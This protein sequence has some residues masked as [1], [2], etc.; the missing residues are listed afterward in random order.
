M[1]AEPTALA[2][3]PPAPPVIDLVHCLS[4]TFHGLPL[5]FHFFS[6]TFHC[7]PLTFTTVS[8]RA[9]DTPMILGSAHLW[10]MY[11]PTKHHSSPGA[12]HM[13]AGALHEGRVGLEEPG[14]AAGRRLRRESGVGLAV[15]ETVIL[16]HPPL[17]LV[18]V[19]I[20]MKRGRQ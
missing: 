1:F 6:L 8:P 3:R 15:G 5:T 13:S 19:S 9:N 2:E 7:L 18:G 4:L 14:G 11:T 16:L 17:H 10:Q 20:G 12:N